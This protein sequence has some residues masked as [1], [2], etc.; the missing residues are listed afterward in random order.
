ML[1][2]HLRILITDD[3]TFNILALIGLFKS[4]VKNYTVEKAY[5]GDMACKFINNMVEN[6]LEPY[7]IIFMDVQMPVK[8]GITACQ[9]IQQ[10]TKNMSKYNNMI[11]IFCTA[12]EDDS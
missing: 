5:N 4:V 2:T 10:F 1:E 3:N 6:N 12:C 11:I 9:E 8:D 7:H